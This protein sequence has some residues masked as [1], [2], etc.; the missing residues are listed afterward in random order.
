MKIA[1]NI[2]LVLI[3]FGGLQACTSYSTNFNEMEDIDISDIHNMK[4]GKSCS[5][6]LFGGFS[7]PYIKT[8]AIRLKGDE[9][10]VAALKDGNITHV[11]AIDKSLKHYLFYSKNCT[12][13]Y[14]Q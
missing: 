1:F 2:L 8:T 13:V 11:H 6:N 7:L 4:K 9:S 14:G 10:V 3:L 12:I 5:N